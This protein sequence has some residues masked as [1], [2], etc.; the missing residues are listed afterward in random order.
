MAE[1]TD[2]ACVLEGKCADCG[3]ERFFKG[4]DGGLSTNIKCAKCG[5]KFNVI[6]RC[7]VMPSGFVERI[8]N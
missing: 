4:P 2:I 1:K 7:Y 8:G 5:S 3:N 6:P